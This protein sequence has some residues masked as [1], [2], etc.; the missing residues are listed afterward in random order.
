MWIFK[1]SFFFYCLETFSL[2]I[3]SELTNVVFLGG[4][5]VDMGEVVLL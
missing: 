5:D 3:S 2:K 1:L 4:L